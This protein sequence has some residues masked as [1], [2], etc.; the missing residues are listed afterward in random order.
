MTLR[1]YGI[2]HT[3]ALTTSSYCLKG[4]QMHAFVL[5]LLIQDC[6]INPCKSKPKI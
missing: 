1:T 5:N 3:D 6:F 2:S 4:K